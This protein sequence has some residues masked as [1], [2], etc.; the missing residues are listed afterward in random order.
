MAGETAS[1]GRH[2]GIDFSASVRSELRG[3]GIATL[4]LASL[5]TKKSA[6]GRGEEFFI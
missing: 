4:S 6:A 2:K 5:A 3:G 1:K